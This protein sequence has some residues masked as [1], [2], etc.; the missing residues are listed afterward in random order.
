MT[1]GAVIRQDASPQPIQ[2]Q[3]ADRPVPALPVRRPEICA[4]CATVLAPNDYLCRTCRIPRGAI[5]DPYAPIPGRLLHA[6]ALL[7]PPLPP[8]ELQ[9]MGAARQFQAEVPTEVKGGWN[10]GAFWLPFFWG[11]SHRTYQTLIVFVLSLI[12]LT[13]IL[14]VSVTESKSDTTN[15]MV[16]IIFW[17]LG[18]PVSVWYGLKGNEWAWRNRQFHSVDE[19]RKVQKAW[20]VWAVILFAL[21]MVGIAVFFVSV[22]LSS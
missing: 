19:F 8:E 1:C 11:L 5:L 7:N 20:A 13:Y 4:V 10:W 9:G 14:V 22:A 6:S 3:V 12:S 17:L 21:N 16:V 2:T 18:F 15:G